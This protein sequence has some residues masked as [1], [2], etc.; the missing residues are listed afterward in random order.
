MCGIGGI[1]SL[2]GK[3]IK[4][5]KAKARC[6]LSALNHRGPDDRGYFVSPSCDVL[7]VNTRLSIVGTN[8]VFPLPMS[9]KHKN[10][11]LAFNG[12]IY[13]FAEYVQNI[14]QIK[15]FIMIENHRTL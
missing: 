6:L 1:I 3:P 10:T 15:H 9:S 2:T 12:E 13:D 8:D 4:N 11:M 14:L 7:L 5:A